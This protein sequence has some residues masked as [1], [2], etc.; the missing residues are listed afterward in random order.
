MRT[1]VLLENFNET[2]GRPSSRWKDDIKMDVR[3]T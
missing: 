2:L 1:K 3:E